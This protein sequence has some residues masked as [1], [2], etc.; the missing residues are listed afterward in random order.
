MKIQAVGVK[1][2][3]ITENF[4]SFKMFP[5]PSKCL[6]YVKGDFILQKIAYSNGIYMAFWCG[7]E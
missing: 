5:D 1:F 4:Q 6:T 2:H 7:V 3:H